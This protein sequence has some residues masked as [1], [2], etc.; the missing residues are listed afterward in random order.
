MNDE[1]TTWT[2]DASTGLAATGITWTENVVEFP[3]T[4]GQTTTSN[5]IGADLVYR[6][7]SSGSASAAPTMTGTLAAAD[8]GTALWIRQ[9]V[10]VLPPA[11]PRPRQLV[12]S[13]SVM[14][15]SE[16]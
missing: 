2:R 9:R 14:Q 5:D 16:R 15:A 4:H 7:A 8:P 3:A 10:T 1:S 12:V 11:E 13:Q 6:I